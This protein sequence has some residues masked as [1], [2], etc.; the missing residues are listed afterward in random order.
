MRLRLSWLLA[1]LV[2]L[3]L[4]ACDETGGAVSSDVE[5]AVDDAV[6]ARQS[7]DYDQAVA[8]LEATLKTNPT[9]APVRVELA[10][11][12]MERDGIDLLDLDQIASFVTEEAGAQT[13]A[14]SAARSAC[15]FEADPGAV[16]FDPADAV[17]L[18][19]ILAKRGTIRR[20][21][22]L[23]D[24]VLPA[25]LTGFD[26]CTSVVDGE[27]VYDRAAAA[28]AL[29]AQDL[30]DDQIGRLLAV[31]ALGRFLDAYLFVT[32]DVTAQTTWYRLSDGSI[33]VCADDPEALEDQ[34]REAVD[35]IGQSILS[36]DLRAGAFARSSASSEIVTLAVDAFGEIR[37]AV[38]DYCSD[39]Q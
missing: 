18:P 3:P 33:G 11:T 1:A 21:L 30:S 20:S 17:N 7:G 22:E 14:R 28:E 19:E 35:G 27:L 16:A 24:E 37:D 13:A 38:G 15:A 32:E 34:A 25:A 12:V 5:V 4:S 8:I 2:L 23:L 31:N 39:A 29:R 9:S 36:L 10:A 26:I 6:V